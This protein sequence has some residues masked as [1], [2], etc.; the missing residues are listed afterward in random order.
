MSDKPFRYQ[1]LPG[2]GSSVFQRIHLWLG[3]DHLLYVASMP[4]GERYKRFY[5]A[6]IQSFTLR[7]TAK[8]LWMA[9]VWVLLVALLVLPVMMAEEE[10]VRWTFGVLAACFLVL[11]I[12][13]L[14]F[15]P[16]CI[17]SIRTAVQT[18]RLPSLSRVRTA[19]RVLARLRP[20]IEAAQA[21]KAVEPAAQ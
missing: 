3:P 10:A 20:L 21:P 19:R 13:H 14:A 5:F 18:E 4:V 9:F 6:D 2:A 7:R 8:W 17:V 1:R 16:S 15:G 11:L 12:V